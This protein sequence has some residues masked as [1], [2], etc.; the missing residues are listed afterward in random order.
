MY[1]SW[2]DAFSECDEW[3]SLVNVISEFVT[4]RIVTIRQD[5]YD[6]HSYK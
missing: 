3:I 6:L 4:I 5:M 2:V 1:E